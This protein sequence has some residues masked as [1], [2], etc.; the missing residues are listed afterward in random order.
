MC[1]EGRSPGEKHDEDVHGRAGV[2]EHLDREQSSTDWSNDGVD[3]VP[4]GIDPRN[5]ISKELQQ[6]KYA[7]DGDDKRITQ[8]G[9]RFI[10][11]RK[12][13][14]VLMNGEASG[15]HGQIEI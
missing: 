2:T 9:E 8:N 10:R 13:D 14:P 4:G 6:K 5:F 15:E 1:E 12:C 7:S 3:G 11:R